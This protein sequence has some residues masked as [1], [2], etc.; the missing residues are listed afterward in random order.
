MGQNPPEMRGKQA[1]GFLTTT[2]HCSPQAPEKAAQVKLCQALPEPQG[3]KQ[4][5]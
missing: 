5:T 2:P 1:P 4:N 3:K